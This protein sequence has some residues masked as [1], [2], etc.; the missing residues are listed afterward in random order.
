MTSSFAPYRKFW[1]A[2]VPMV[3]IAISMAMP[4][5]DVSEADLNRWFEA[6]MVVATPFLVYF[7]PNSGVPRT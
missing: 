2:A 7:V 4:E 1:A 6:A 3:A 5:S